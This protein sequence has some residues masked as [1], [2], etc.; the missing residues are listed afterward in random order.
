LTK[1]RNLVSIRLLRRMGIETA[2]QHIA[3]FGFDPDQLPHNLSLALGS[4]NVSAL[5]MARAYAV[6]ANGGYLV[7]PY[8]ITRIEQDGNDTVFEANPGIVCRDCEPVQAVSAQDTDAKATAGS[9]A[10]AKTAN[11]APRVLDERNRYLM[12]SMMQ[13]VIQQGT[14]TK[15]KSLGRRDLAG[16][17]GTTNDQ[18]DAWFN[19]FN[20][21]LVANA[22]VGFDDNSQLG[23]GE[24]GGRAALPAWIDFMAVALKDIPDAEPEMPE[25]MVK[26]RIDPRTGQP[27]TAATEGAFFEVFRTEFAPGATVAAGET[28]DRPAVVRPAAVVTPPPPTQD[29][30]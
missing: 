17:T 27:A 6:L 7:D 20:Q 15:A 4:A 1:S 16:K 12:Y 11:H 14:A 2:L 21:Q 30:F 26:V 22:W 13:D 3:K 28:E 5:E 9:E 8:L 10:P 29:L 25:D 23:R 19:G 18:R 24:V